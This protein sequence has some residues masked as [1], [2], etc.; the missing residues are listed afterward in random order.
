MKIPTQRLIVSNKHIS[1]SRHF[2]G[3]FIIDCTL[4]TRIT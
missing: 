2:R 3:P 1:A 4:Q